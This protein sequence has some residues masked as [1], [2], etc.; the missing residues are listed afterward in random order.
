MYLLKYTYTLNFI[1]FIGKCQDGLNAC[2]N[3]YILF[4]RFFDANDHMLP[5]YQKKP[6]DRYIS[7]SHG[8]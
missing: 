6:S 8:F 1:I 4:S 5:I 7:L 3:D 2:I